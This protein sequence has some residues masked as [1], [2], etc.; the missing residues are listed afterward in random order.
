MPTPKQY[1]SNAARQAAYRARNAESKPATEAQLATLARSLHVVLEDAIAHGRSGLPAEL[2][3][4]HAAATLRN[5]I[6]YLEVDPD[7]V[8]QG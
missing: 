6:R 8:R 7:P 3:G 1:A 5:L 4:E 2:V